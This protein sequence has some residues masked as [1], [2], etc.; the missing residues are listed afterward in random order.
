VFFDVFRL[1]SWGVLGLEFLIGFGNVTVF[2]GFGNQMSLGYFCGCS[3]LC[4]TKFLVI[5]CSDLPM[6]L[7][8]S[9]RIGMCQ[10]RFDVSNLRMSLRSALGYCVYDICVRWFPCLAEGFGVRRYK[11]FRF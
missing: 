3:G 10:F 8:F 9:L 5:S 7:P 6:V 4:F 11:M 1:Y 2:F